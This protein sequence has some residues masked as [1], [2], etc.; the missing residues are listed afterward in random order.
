M[1]PRPG[2]RNSTNNR[3]I[4]QR[5]AVIQRAFFF[6]VSDMTDN[7]P[8]M[9]VAVNQPGDYRAGIWDYKGTRWSV[10]DPD[11]VLPLLFPEQ[12]EK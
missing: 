5:P 8:H 4:N 3:S 7:I 6:G 1:K 11:G 2:R 10:F 12:I 9:I